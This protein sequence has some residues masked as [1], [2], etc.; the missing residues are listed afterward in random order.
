DGQSRGDN[1]GTDTYHQSTVRDPPPKRPS[2]HW[3]PQF[4]Q[5]ARRFRCW[6]TDGLATNDGRRV[7]ASSPLFVADRTD[8]GY[9]ASIV[10]NRH[11][12]LLY[13]PYELSVPAISRSPQTRVRD[14]GP[15]R[16]FV[17][18]AGVRRLRSVSEVTYRAVVDRDTGRCRVVPRRSH[19]VGGRYGRGPAEV[20]ARRPC[21]F[22]SVR[23]RRDAVRLSHSR[24]PGKLDV[25]RPLLP[26]RRRVARRRVG[27]GT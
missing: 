15:D 16:A 27:G 5:G 14:H 21:T 9:G 22:C 10:I 4:P 3:S 1:R 8:V 12:R 18:A 7:N 23:H 25:V 19:R 6:L 24:D 13:W 20:L 2:G 26:E 11:I 17:C